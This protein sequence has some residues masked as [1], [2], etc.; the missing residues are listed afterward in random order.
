MGAWFTP[1]SMARREAACLLD[2]SF[3]TVMA[4]D[5]SSEG[6]LRV[7]RV[8]SI[9]HVNSCDTSLT[10]ILE[11][12]CFCVHL[13]SYAARTRRGCNFVTC[14]VAGSQIHGATRESTSSWPGNALHMNPIMVP[15]S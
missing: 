9:G 10:L 11:T 7:I 2:R 8:V 13:C 12:M 1:C 14:V 15:K 4:I 5:P 6:R 3:S